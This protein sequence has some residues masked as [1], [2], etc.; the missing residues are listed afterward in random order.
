MYKTLTYLNYISMMLPAYSLSYIFLGL[1]FHNKLLLIPLMLAALPL[2]KIK[3]KKYSIPL[4]FLTLLFFSYSVIAFLNNWEYLIYFGYFLTYF[5]LIIT[6]MIIRL[7]EEHFIS[8]FKLFFQL[9]ILYTVVQL[10]ILNLGFNGIAMIHSNLP[11][12]NEYTIPVFIAEP[13]YRYT[14]LF[15]ESS[16]YAFYLIIC[17]SFFKSLGKKYTMY[18]YCAL[19]F[20]VISGSKAAYLFLIL[21]NIFFTKKVFIKLL[22]LF[23]LLS[24][25]YL[26]MFELNFLLE[27]TSGQVASVIKRLA[28]LDGNDFSMF[29]IG[30]GKSSEGEVPLNM[31]SIL[32]S[33]FGYL[34]SSLI[35]GSLY[36]FYLFIENPNK[37]DFILPFIVGAISNGSLLIFQYSL[38]I[39]CLIH[40][41]KKRMESER[42]LLVNE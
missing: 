1:Y 20:L 29:G 27:I 36:L 14:G 19:F 39:Y 22:M 13:F 34:G 21:Y 42:N 23:A 16:P 8:F 35:I 6:I 12:Q 31:L 28:A 7:E 40:L 10:V 18:R 26:Y 38:I 17:F 41:H 37:K 24:L 15:N 33:G 30:L 2:V 3:I 9:N 5:S 4:L 11:A 25:I 32:I